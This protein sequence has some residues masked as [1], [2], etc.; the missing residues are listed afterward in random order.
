MGI[1]NL[2]VARYVVQKC[3]AKTQEKN[4][5][6]Q[7]KARIISFVCHVVMRCLHPKAA[8]FVHII[9]PLLKAHKN[10]L[11][12]W[13]AC[14]RAEQRN[15]EDRVLLKMKLIFFLFRIEKFLFRNGNTVKPALS[16]HPLLSG[17]QPKS[18]NLFS[19]FTLN[20][21]FIKWRPLLSRRGHVKSIRYGHFYCCQPA[22]NGHL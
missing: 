5:K 8:V 7:L 1:R 21:T 6:R 17:Q 14:S 3:H 10:H 18:P 15:Y 11:M 4:G 12:I 16:G 22:L 19:L 9:D 13:G 20:E 2:Q